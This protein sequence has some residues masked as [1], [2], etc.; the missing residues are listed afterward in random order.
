M[1]PLD[2]RKLFY[3]LPDKYLLLAADGRVVDLNDSHAASSLGGR[4]RQEVAGHD[5]FEVW[6]PTSDT[7]G[8]VVRQSHEQ[9][10]R[11]RR[12]HTMPLIRYDVPNAAAP[13]GY[14][15]RYWEAT[16]YPVVDEDGELR[17]IL[18]RTEDVTAQQLAEA[19]RAEAQSTLR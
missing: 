14:E 7:E 15:Q 16:H 10:R 3:S 12:P 11:T 6:P 18:Q 9:V 13:A 17:Y 2:F 5:F 1:T 8:D 19:R 4:S